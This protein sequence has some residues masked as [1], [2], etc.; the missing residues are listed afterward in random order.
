MTITYSSTAEGLSSLNFRSAFFAGW[1]KAPSVDLLLDILAGSD[2]V[3]IARDLDLVVGFCAAISDGVFCAYISLLEVLPEYQG[4]QIGSNLVQR[5]RS[6]I[7]TVYMLDAMCDEP[8]IEFYS[9]LG[10]FQSAGVV[11]RNRAAIP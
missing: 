5:V 11:I 2:H 9:K 6:E 10:F 3:V 1:P 4:Q 7:G 8:Q